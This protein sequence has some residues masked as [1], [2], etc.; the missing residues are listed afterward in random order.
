[1]PT[2]IAKYYNDELV[3]WVRLMT[4]YN[5]EIDQFELKLAEVIQRNTI[6]G[7]AAK[8]EAHQEKLNTVSQKFTQLQKRIL[9]Q[10]GWLK[11]D[12]TFIDD[13]TIKTETDEEQKQIRKKME[14]IEKEYIDVKYGCYQFLSE[15]LN[16][17]NP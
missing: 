7:I 6:P 17:Q 10:K 8:V 5:G 2:T 4:F 3:E 15:T 9:E 13:T 1:M 14:E 16:K 11:T 12:S